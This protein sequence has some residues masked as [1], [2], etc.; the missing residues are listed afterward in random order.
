RRL[1][2][3]PTARCLPARPTAAAAGAR[4]TR[5]NGPA[6]RGL[7]LGPRPQG[8]PEAPELS[9]PPS[10]R[11]PRAQFLAPRVRVGVPGAPAARVAVDAL[12]AGARPRGQ[13]DGGPRVRPRA[14]ELRREGVERP[15]QGLH[16]RA[17]QVVRRVRRRE[18]QVDV[19]RGPPGRAAQPRG[20]APAAGSAPRLV[21]RR[22]GQGRVLV[23]QVRRGRQRRP[24]Q[25]RVEQVPGPARG[26]LPQVPQGAVFPVRADILRQGLDGLPG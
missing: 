3:S 10:P 12:R 6:A 24:G 9:P 14:R 13:A 21:D 26:L 20:C 11:C 5:S 18:R 15:V 25:G 8:P 17:E 23:E 22:L 7:V 4:G 19:R 1:G 2:R 16:D